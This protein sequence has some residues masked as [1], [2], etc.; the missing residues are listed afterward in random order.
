M[1]RVV[2]CVK[3]VS[4][5]FASTV[6]S[7]S[8]VPSKAHFYRHCTV[9]SLSTVRYKNI[10]NM[11]LETPMLDQFNMLVSPSDIRSFNLACAKDYTSHQ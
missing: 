1:E 2:S 5:K 7:T 8:I 10:F 9:S 4:Y 11:L 3:N 6:D